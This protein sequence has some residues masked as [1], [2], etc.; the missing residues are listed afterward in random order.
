MNILGNLKN[1]FATQPI[2]WRHFFVGTRRSHYY[3]RESEE[4]LIRAFTGNDAVY[5]VINYL[6][7]NLSELP[8]Q[9]LRG[10]TEVF[11]ESNQYAKIMHR[12]GAEGFYYRAAVML[13]LTGDLFIIKSQD[14]IG[15]S[16]SN[17]LEVLYSQYVEIRR[18]YMHAPVDGYDYTINGKARHY[19]PDE[20]IHLQYFDPDPDNYCSKGLSPFQPG[21]WLLQSNNNLTVGES[22]ILENRGASMLVSA[23]DSSVPLGKN[24][25][26]RL[27]EGTVGRMGGA[28]KMG[29][30]KYLQSAVDIHTLGMSPADLNLIEMYPVHLRRICSLL[31][32]PAELFNAQGSG[33]F[34]TRKEA[35]K[36][37]FAEAI[38]PMAKMIYSA[39]TRGIEDWTGS[40]YSTKINRDEIEALN[41]D[42]TE[43]YN[44]YLGW[45]EM[46][47][48]SRE[49][50]LELVN[51]ED[52]GKEFVKETGLAREGA[53]GNG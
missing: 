27:D 19:E 51:I 18:P 24:D 53:Q 48:I 21:G 31:N 39:I 50:F 12:P 9:Y 22:Q 33:Q 43:L 5:S 23:K 10:E 35:R 6:A 14:S 44:T 13:A 30:I 25:L 40:G 29:S 16:D 11:S 37:A 7:Q 52:N 3:R 15:F 34:N 42:R 20:I 4:T 47:A 26:D 36:A 2:H 41:P 38:I 28:D 49:K 45:F 1:L 32:L 17:R 8:V 46:G